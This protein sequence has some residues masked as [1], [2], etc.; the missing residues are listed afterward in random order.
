[1]HVPGFLHDVFISYACADDEQADGL[2]GHF[3][4]LL[5]NGLRAQGL[6][7][8]DAAMPD[9]VDIFLDRQRLQAGA[10]LTE[11]VLTA[12]RSSAVF[13]AFHSLAYVESSW[14]RREAAEFIGN[15]DACRPKLNGRL[16]VVSLGK[17]GAPSESPVEALRSRR[18][19]RFYSVNADGKDFPFEPAMDGQPAEK[20]EDGYSLKQEALE[21]SREIADTLRAMREESPAPRV[22]LADTSPARQ[23][24]ADDVK[25]WLLQH[26]VLVLRAAPWDGDWE[27]ESRE[28][29][30]RADV[31]VDLHEATPHAPAAA[32]AQ[33]AKTLGKR[34]VRWLPRGELAA[35]AAQ[36]LMQE[37][38]V[39][40]ETLEDFKEALHR[41][42]T[43][44]GER[45][46]AAVVAPNDTG[47][48]AGELV[49]LVAAKKDEA[50]LAA[51][52]QKLDEIG[53]GRDAFVS[54][55]VIENPD[56]WR[57]D[58]QALLDFHGPA[59]VVFVDGACEGK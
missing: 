28:M 11:Q 10:D 13:I 17:R 33:L 5:G 4:K 2:I 51:L 31:F 6:R 32:Q 7:L 56:T 16:F 57:K 44:P 26:Q 21:L 8:H 14:C 34:R 46:K 43:Q 39:I 27:K 20:N 48:A 36:A 37:T 45:H 50:F 9:G 24:A 49:L 18:F 40:E 25:N 53:C 54:E 58:L 55:D 35:E 12:A 59:G 29:I 19:R 42:L 1:M 47:V 52:E 15:Y 23:A 3:A 22:F 41:L 30:G 38:D